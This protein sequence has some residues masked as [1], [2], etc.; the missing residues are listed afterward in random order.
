M[1]ARIIDERDEICE[2]CEICEND[3]NVAKNVGRST[4]IDKKRHF[5]YFLTKLTATRL[6]IIARNIFILLV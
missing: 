5:M 4:G 1:P 3:Q 6:K 2:I